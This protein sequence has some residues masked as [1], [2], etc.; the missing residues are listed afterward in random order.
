[1][2][3]IRSGVEKN[4]RESTEVEE[5]AAA[6]GIG[7]EEA[8]DIRGEI[9]G[10]RELGRTQETFEEKDMEGD[11]EDDE[12]DDDCSRAESEPEKQSSAWESNKERGVPRKR[13]K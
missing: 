1:M 13:E 10:G 4:W 11:E 6:S 9:N 12:E 5:D 7:L 8:D 3:G 2:S